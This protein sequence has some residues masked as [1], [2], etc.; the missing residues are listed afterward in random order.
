MNADGNCQYIHL[1]F[2][3]LKQKI[4]IIINNMQITKESKALLNDVV[5]VQIQKDDYLPGFENKVKKYS[6]TVDVKGFR[7]GMVPVGMVKKMY[8]DGI[9]AEE[10]NAL[11]DKS[12]DNFI[13]EN[14]IKMLGRPIPSESQEQIELKWQENKDYTFEFEIGYQPDI[15]L[16][17]GKHVFKKYELK[18]D[19]SIVEKEMENVTKYFQ[20]LEDTSDPI[21]END[22][23]YFKLTDG[24]EY[25]SDSFCSTNDLTKAGSKA[26]IRKKAGDKVEGKVFDLINNE[27]LDIKKFVFNLKAE[28][29][30]D[31]A[32]ENEN[33]TFEITNVKTTVVPKELTADQI[34]LITRDE[35]KTTLEELKLFLG[36]EIK[37]QYVN[38]SKNYLYTDIYKYIIEDY[39]M[40]LPMEFMKKWLVSEKDNNLTPETVEKELSNIEKQVKWDV[41]SNQFATQNEIK[42]EF[43]EIK[44]EFA[45]R[46]YSYFAQSG[47]TPDPAQIEGFVK[48]SMKDQKQVQK[49]YETILDEKLLSKMA[50]GV[51][52]ETVLMTEEEFV[53]ESAKRNEK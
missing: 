31:P 28:E 52:T 50:E 39:K 33:L 1:R 23:I 45:N 6:K 43:E 37:A 35:N 21:K 5:K 42:V 10:I 53:T 27:K 19:V 16:N 14:N 47:Y 17:F 46:Y 12:L 40:D 49:V 26:F 25:T 18:F 22:T 11:I 51:K 7:K 44:N 29:T 4:N 15:T 48:E 38:I 34:K 36:D 13:K 9:L 41:V 24:K 8:G 3:Y 30:L 20:K 32:L 2:F